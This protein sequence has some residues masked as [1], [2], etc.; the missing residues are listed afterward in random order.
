MRRLFALLSLGGLAWWLLGRR[1]ERAFPRV[2][3]GYEDG[4]SREP[5]PGTP[6]HESLLR[7][8]ARAARR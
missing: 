4:L 3:I 6:E 2:V 8:A 5:D 7:I 1:R